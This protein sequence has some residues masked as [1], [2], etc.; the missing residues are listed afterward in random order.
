[1]VIEV[2]REV[3]A[4]LREQ[5]VW[6][7]LPGADQETALQ[8]SEA[9]RRFAE[10]GRARH[11]AV[12]VEGR[13]VSAADVYSWWRNCHQ[14]PPRRPIV[15][16]GSLASMGALLFQPKHFLENRPRLFAIRDEVPNYIL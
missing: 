10:V 3:L 16:T 9:N 6:E 13:P 4:S 8:I 15:A 11:F 14:N 2:E 12:T 7:T 1:M 5:I